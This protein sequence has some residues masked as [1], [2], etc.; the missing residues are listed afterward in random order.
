[1]RMQLR[2]SERLKM[3]TT[4]TARQIL[5]IGAIIALIW[6]A[7][8]GGDVFARS[9]AAQPPKCS[10]LDSVKDLKPARTTSMLTVEQ[11]YWC[12]LDHY[13]TGNHLDDRVLLRGA[14][15][16]IAKLLKQVGID[17]PTPALV[18]KRGA[19]WQSFS[20]TVTKLIAGTPRLSVIGGYIA[21]F[22]ID[23][24]TGSLKDDHTGYLPA[25]YMKLELEQL[26]DGPTPS[27]GM[28]TTTFTDTIKSPVYVTNVFP[29]SPASEAGV[30]AGDTITGINGQPAETSGQPNPGWLNILIPQT[31]IS[32][33]LTTRRPATGASRTITLMARTMVVPASTARVVGSNIGYVRLYIFSHHSAESVFQEIKA[34]IAS[35]T[36]SG[37]VLDLRGNPGGE[38]AQAIRL[39]S[40]F[41][42]GVTVG[43]SIDS[44]GKRT[45]Q[46][47]DDSVP[48]IQLPLAVLIDD[49]SASSS[50]LVAGVMRD[51]GVA[52][53][54]G[55]RTAG[56]INEAFFFGL[57]DGGGMEIT[58]NRVLGPMAEP[59]DGVGVAPNDVATATA[60]D[61]SAGRDPVLDMAVRY[62]RTVAPHQ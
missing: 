50:E 8:V 52:R 12:I 1:M 60:A 16:S 9:E 15:T 10:G 20:S 61:L 43:Y 45:A 37:L 11:G 17:F 57:N 48:I 56:V 28:I 2:S 25:Q 21:Q 5:S 18:G 40:A 55:R 42:H 49:G 53:V 47:T 19:D 44:N 4:M 59:V 14:S 46:T 38:E 23:G 13:V 39:V 31:G 27:L 30:R 62:L 36:L 3:I 26:T 29:N 7:V 35:R 54:I 22:A 24:M 58:A 33:S 6:S 34:M 51:Y 41:V 32:V